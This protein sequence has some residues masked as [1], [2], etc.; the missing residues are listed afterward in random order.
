M[1]GIDRI[2]EGLGANEGVMDLV[3]VVPDNN[4]YF[5][6]YKPESLVKIRNI[7]ELYRTYTVCPKNKLFVNYALRA[8]V[9]EMNS[10]QVTNNSDLYFLTIQI[11]KSYSDALFKRD[12]DAI[13][14]KRRPKP[15]EKL[16]NDLRRGLF[17]KSNIDSYCY[18]LERSLNG[19]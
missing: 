16:S 7:R 8:C 18:V 5:K 2:A 6:D 1:F 4:I 12:K 15:M 3:S 19:R 10:L 14:F 9:S 13:A 17:L 11:D